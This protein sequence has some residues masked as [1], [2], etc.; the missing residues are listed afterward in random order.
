MLEGGACTDAKQ[1][2]ALHNTARAAHGSKPLVWS[3]T[4]ARSATKWAER[5]IWSHSQSEYGENILM[6][7]GTSTT[8]SMAMEYWYDNERDDYSYANPGYQPDAGHF[9][10]VVWKATSQLGCGIA[11]CDA[12]TA[13]PSVRG[14][15]TMMV[16]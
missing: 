8:C 10:Q 11:A 3:A 13:P 9:S 1:L 4:V 14:P 12:S 6:S 16:W 5:C 7:W 15:W 2:L